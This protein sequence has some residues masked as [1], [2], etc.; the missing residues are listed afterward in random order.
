MKSTHSLAI[1]AAVGVLLTMNASLHADKTDDRIVSSAKKS[2][3]FKTYLKDDAIK[4]ESRNGKV[5]LT[6]TVAEASHKTLAADTVVN[7]MTVAVP[8]A[9][10]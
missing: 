3:V 8:V 6:G 10:K 7:D 9:A 2:H 1:V 5:I 4:T